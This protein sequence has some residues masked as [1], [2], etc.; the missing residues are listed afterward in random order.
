MKVPSIT[1]ELLQTNNAEQSLWSA[2]FA[3]PTNS[4]ESYVIQLIQN[5]LKIITELKSINRQSPEIEQ[6]IQQYVNETAQWAISIGKFELAVSLIGENSTAKEFYEA[7]VRDDSLWCEHLF[8]KEIDGHLQQNYFREFDYFSATHG[9]KVSM[10]RCNECGFRNAK[11]LT[12]DLK[13]LSEHRANVR[14]GGKD[15]SNLREIL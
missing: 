4:Q 13:K 7:E 15:V 1:P 3:L 14:R 6:K 12:A 10:L 11:D 8:Y 2:Q 5:N 9:R